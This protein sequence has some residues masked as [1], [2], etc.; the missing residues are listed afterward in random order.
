VING[1]QTPEEATAQL[2]S[3]LESWYTPQ[4]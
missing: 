4:K 2:Q 1:T 3:G